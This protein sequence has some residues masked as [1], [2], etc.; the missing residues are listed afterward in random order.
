MPASCAG[1]KKTHKDC[2]EIVK[3]AVSVGVF[4]GRRGRGSPVGS[5]NIIGGGNLLDSQHVVERL[6]RGGQR[7][8]PLLLCHDSSRHKLRKE[9]R[10]VSVETLGSAGV[11]THG[12]RCRMRPYRTAARAFEERGRPL[13]VWGGEAKRL[14]G[15]KQCL[16]VTL[17][18]LD[19]TWSV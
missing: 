5:L 14:S 17:H 8:L 7:A 11:E 2:R 13:H 1:R 18:W 16:G 3:V 19:G 12:R 6:A 15:D 9:T 10:H 4:M